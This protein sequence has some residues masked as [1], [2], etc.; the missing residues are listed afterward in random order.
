[1]IRLLSNFLSKSKQEW[2]NQQEF[3][4]EEEFS[5]RKHELFIKLSAENEAAKQK[6]ETRNK[7]LNDRLAETEE[8]LKKLNLKQAT[9]KLAE[10]TL[11]ANYSKNESDL[12]KLHHENRAKLETHFKQELTELKHRHDLEKKRVEDLE[13]RTLDRKEEL[14]KVNEELKTQI[15][16]IE[17]KARPDSI[18]INAFSAGANRAF[19]S[20]QPIINEM[21][22]KSKKVIEE[23]AIDES[24]KRIQPII[25]QRIEQLKLYHL[26][27]V[28]EIE[29]KRIILLEKLNKSNK[30]E[31]KLRRQHYVEAIDWML[32]GN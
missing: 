19:E 29:S 1:M 21:I 2:I 4:L 30:E 5:E 7:E 23:R 20:F 13:V 31:D 26:K 9:L 15:R 10:E 24:L 27:P 28:Q 12:E 8:T 22:E 32:N 17:A 6:L 25:D 3:K 11:I 14:A 18:W 16:L